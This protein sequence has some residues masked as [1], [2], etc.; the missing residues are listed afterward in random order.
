[1]F[2]FFSADIQPM[3]MQYKRSKEEMTTMNR[4]KKKR[5]MVPIYDFDDILA[6]KKNPKKIGRMSDPDAPGPVILDREAWNR[7][8][9]GGKH[10]C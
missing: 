5:K 1:M 2:I 3:W 7:L 4:P 8:I 9:E 10:G 6:G